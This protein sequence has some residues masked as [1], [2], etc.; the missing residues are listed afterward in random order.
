M[1]TR[2]LIC[3]VFLGDLAASPEINYP[4]VVDSSKASA[5]NHALGPPAP[6]LFASKRPK[7]PGAAWSGLII[8]W[9]NMN[10]SPKAPRLQRKERETP[11]NLHRPVAAI[12]CVRFIFG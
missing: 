10:F 12:G 9:Q 1:K 11:R 4:Q 8:G 2:C 3:Q 6:E 7:L 5:S